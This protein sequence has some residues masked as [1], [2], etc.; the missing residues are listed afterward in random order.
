MPHKHAVYLLGFIAGGVLLGGFCGWYFGAS[1][2]KV[3]WL[4]TLFLNLLKMTIIPLI[5]T[6]VV[7]GVA[8]MGKAGNMGRI[9]GITVFYYLCTTGIAVFIGLVV[10][11]I[12]RPGADLDLTGGE[13]SESIIAKQ[14]TG[15]SDIILSMVSPNLVMS[16]AETQLLPIILFSIVFAV[17]INKLGDKGKPLVA[18][19]DSANEVMMKI[20]TWIMYLAPVGIFALIAGRLGRAGGGDAF[21]V[22]IK[23]VGWH[24]VTVLSGLAIHLVVLFI[25]LYLVTGRGFGYFMGM[26]RALLTAFGTASSSA[27]LPL[28]MECAHENKL[29][30]RAIRFVLPLGSTVNMDGTA[31]YEAAAVMFIAQGYGVDMGLTQQVIIFITATLAAIGAAGIPEAG[32]VTMVIV[33]QAVGLPLEG[34]GLL[35][36][37]DW[38]LDRFRTSI[39]VWGDSVGA[40]IIHRLLQK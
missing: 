13:I 31:L 25:I 24:M 17:A 39:N 8:S 23:A 27:T 33:L 30:E 15:I 20:V 19:F 5:V 34:I 3:A 22:E 9:G 6:A 29:D 11:N 32:L 18:F 12:I 21:M 28:T 40:A 36:A 38:L 26:A 35:L 16:A 7:S 37:V 14:D 4:G 10:V 1:M 2:V